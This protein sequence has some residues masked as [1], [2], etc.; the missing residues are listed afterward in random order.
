M[1]YFDGSSLIVDRKLCCVVELKDD[2]KGNSYNTVGF[3]TTQIVN[4]SYGLML[5]YLK[6]C[7]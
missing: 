4:H 1:L 7:G 3:A 5:L 2:T 6:P